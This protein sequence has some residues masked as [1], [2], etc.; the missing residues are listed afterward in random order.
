MLD[1][2][3]EGRSLQGGSIVYENGA[4]AVPISQV[5]EGAPLS[6][7]TSLKELD[8]RGE[9]VPTVAKSNF[10]GFAQFAVAT[11]KRG[12]PANAPHEYRWI[13]SR[14]EGRATMLVHWQPTSKAKGKAV[15]RVFNSDNQ[16][17]AESKPEN[18]TLTPGNFLATSWD[19]PLG[20]L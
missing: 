4:M 3:G 20:N 6:A 12:N 5:P 14:R 10:I 9:F 7:R 2:L 18:L 17:V 8:R 13:F 15:L 19:L 16:K 1:L 11:G